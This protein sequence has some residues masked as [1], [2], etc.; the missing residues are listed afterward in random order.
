MACQI[1][2]LCSEL[3]HRLGARLLA[4]E[5]KLKRLPLAEQ[6]AL[7]AT[8]LEKYPEQETKRVPLTSQMPSS[9]CKP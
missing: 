9:P 3:L 5:S 7:K 1:E 6:T 4:V 2:L 8:S